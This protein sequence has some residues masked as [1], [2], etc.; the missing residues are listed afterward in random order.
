MQDSN[1]HEFR[2]T[3]GAQPNS[4]HGF[5]RGNAMLAASDPVKTSYSIDSVA[6]ERINERNANRLIRLENNDVES[7]G[8]YSQ[9]SSA[10]VKESRPVTFGE[11]RPQ[12][13][14]N[15]YRPESNQLRVVSKPSGL[16]P[17]SQPQKNELYNELEEI[18][19]M[20]AKILRNT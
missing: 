17:R 11:Q 3:K 10:N 18:D 4:T 8:F 12:T 14:G 19:D 20:L 9:Q 16:P 1:Y 2:L 15:E 6:L 7:A 5:K 13:F